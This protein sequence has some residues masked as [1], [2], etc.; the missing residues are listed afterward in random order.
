MAK[1]G[2][3]FADGLASL[4]NSNK[5]TKPTESITVD[6]FI[7]GVT[8]GRWKKIVEQY[9]S[10]N[11]KKIKDALPGVTISAQLKSR[12]KK[13]E[14]SKRIIAHSGFICLDIDRKDNPDL[15]SQDLVDKDCYAQFRS[16][17]GEGIK[18]IYR[19]TKTTDAATHRR[20]YD[21][22]LQRLSKKKINLKVDPIVKS[23]A[24]L[25]YVSYDPECYTNYKTK[26]IAVPLPPI[27]RRIPKR[28]NDIKADTK[29]LQDYIN[30]LG[31]KDITSNYEDWMI[32]MFGLS[33]SLGEQGR[34]YMHKICKNYKGYSKA[35]C[36]EKYDG[37]LE[38]NI[39]EIENPITI[40]SVYQ[41]IISN[42]SKAK[43]KELEKKYKV[44]HAIGV[45]EDEEQEDL[46][47]M[48]RYKL[49]LFK[50]IYDKTNVLVEL[51]PAK[52]NLNAFEA[53]LKQMG[54]M[55]YGSLYVRIVDNIVEPADEGDILRMVTE[56][57]EKEGD[58]KFT[59]K[60][61]EF[62]FSWEELAHIWRENRSRSTIT[63]QIK[64]A[65]THWQPN[66]LKDTATE[67]FIPYLNGVLRITAKEIKLLPYSAIKQQIWKERIL[68]RNFRQNIK[69]GMFEEFFINVNG[70]K[71]NSERYR[72]ALWY[73]G[74]MLQGTKRQSTA[75]AWLLYDSRTGK[76][77][78]TGKTIIGTAIGK[79]RSVVYIDGKHFDNRNRFMFQSVQPWTNVIFIDDPYKNM[80]LD[81]IFNMISG[82]V[83]ADRKNIDPLIK[84]DIKIMIAS[85]WILENEG[86][87]ERGRQFVTQLDDFYV[88]YGKKNNNTIT[89][90][91]DYHGKEFFTDW[92]TK[93]WEQFDT[94]SARAIQHHLKTKAP[95]ATVIGN[96]AKLRFIQLHDEDI[97]DMLKITFNANVVK[98]G[99]ALYI[100]KSIMVE[101][102][103]NFDEKLT[104]ITAGKI[105]REW[106]HSVGI[107]NVGSTSFTKGAITTMMY[108]IN[109]EN[110]KV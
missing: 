32:V 74:Y 2:K 6:Q 41:L 104:T 4:F 29:Q 82:T 24:S 45:G 38:R 108:K 28:T 19:C 107:T 7:E 44:S 99:G 76:N 93:D 39:E 64:A 18:I 95:N 81:P 66:L 16:C 106:F 72:K 80:S 90:I 30:A 8:N 3:V 10:S 83:Y 86:E 34:P 25:Q 27:Q 57:V 87:S 11:D 23:I 92:D 54:F 88:Q 42:L 53:L 49:F 96:A 94:F 89:P 75:R 70:G 59:Y 13:V 77:G 15:R 55:R 21:G 98:K 47:G 103:K 65:L 73:Y 33:Y 50:K 48:V 36:D 40:A 56:H 52:I 58:Y 102:V 5:A 22:L 105:V 26:F 110:L 109:D 61:A 67:S 46:I 37:C 12:D 84:D 9:R 60:K 14:I 43:V 68:P 1:N 35:E 91:V 85:N 97:Y 79:I 71:K 63:N 20:I 101:A 17:G 100:P 69:T 78:R 51:V 31:R 62:H